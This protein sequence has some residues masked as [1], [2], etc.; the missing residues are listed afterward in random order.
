MPKPA[1]GFCGIKFSNASN[2]RRH[3]TRC[4]ASSQEDEAPRVGAKKGTGIL[5]LVLDSCRV[6]GRLFQSI[7]MPG[8]GLSILEWFLRIVIV[9]PFCIWMLFSFAFQPLRA[10]LYV[11]G[12]I[13]SLIWGVYE[14]FGIFPPV[15][16]PDTNSTRANS[17]MTIYDKNGHIVEGAKVVINGETVNAIKT[18]G[19]RTVDFFA[20]YISGYLFGYRNQN[21]WY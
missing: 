12:N 21:N 11:L 20:H 17:T 4:G 10:L 15:I 14:S 7:F 13:A 16:G 8:F 3:V 9:W 5:R 19:V 2:L 18:F 1:C 6:F